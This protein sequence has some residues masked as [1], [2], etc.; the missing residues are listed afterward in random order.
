MLDSDGPNDPDLTAAGRSAELRQEALAALTRPLPRRPLFRRIGTDRRRPADPDH[1]APGSV[2]PAADRPASGVDAV[3]R[4]LRR[5]AG[6]VPGISL[7]KWTKTAAVLLVFV[8]GVGAWMTLRRP[9]TAIDSLP[10]AGGDRGAP[11]TTSPPAKEPGRVRSGPTGSGP[12]SGGDGVVTVHVAGAVSRPGVVSLPSGSR[13]V[14]AVAAAGGLAAGA[15]PDRMNLAAPLLDGERL[16]VPV[17]GQP[18]P[19]EVPP[20]LPGGGG[21]AGSVGSV[22]AAKIDLNTATAEQLD[23]LPG[24][25][26]STAAAIVAHRNQKGP[27]RTVEGLLDVRGIGDAKFDA[28]RDLV[29]AGAG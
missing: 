17:V 1:P 27:F 7:P 25:G 29:T 26:P 28:L 11:T 18:V 4:M 20:L 5:P 23:T 10:R 21:V 14:D 16:V 2:D 9:T 15:D 3:V 19:Q 8:V 24:V 13:A 22:A 6:P 12:Q